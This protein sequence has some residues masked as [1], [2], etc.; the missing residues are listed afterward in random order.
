M[1]IAGRVVIHSL[2]F[3]LP[4]SDGLCLTSSPAAFDTI[5]AHFSDLHTGPE[6]FDL[7]V[8]GDLGALGKD[9]LIQLFL[10][11]GISIGGKL[12]DCGELVFDRE[13]QDVHCGGSGCG[14]SAIV[15]CSEL[16]GK[17]YQGKL[18]KILFCGTGALLSPTS[19]QQNLPI[20]GVCHGVCIESRR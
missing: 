4:E 13:R 8:T 7:I 20:P 3:F 16:L 10:R 17:L 15:L 1:T 11:E 6:D 18:K 9:A 14:C 2:L 12:V 19:T 5:R